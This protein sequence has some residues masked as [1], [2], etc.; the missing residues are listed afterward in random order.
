MGR[1]LMKASPR[2]LNKERNISESPE[3]QKEIEDQEKGNSKIM[4]KISDQMLNQIKKYVKDEVKR[5]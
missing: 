4:R 3:R 2:K 1:H 5:K